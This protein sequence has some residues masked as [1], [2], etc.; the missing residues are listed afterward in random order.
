M[1]L[2]GLG[3][4]AR[5]EAETLVFSALSIPR[6][7]AITDPDWLVPEALALRL[8][9]WAHLLWDVVAMLEYNSVRAFQ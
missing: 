5:R 1:A 4:H 9:Q 8:Q 7:R 2:D 6:S 3:E